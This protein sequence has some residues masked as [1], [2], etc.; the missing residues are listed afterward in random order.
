MPG[1]RAGLLNRRITIQQGQPGSGSEGDATMTW[2]PLQDVWAG[3]SPLGTQEL[4][5]AA[6]RAEEITHNIT[7]RF[8]RE[9]QAPEN[10]RLLFGNRIF[11]VV[12]A[13]D[14]DEGQTMLV[15]RCQEYVVGSQT[16]AS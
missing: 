9:F 12:G 4:I 8:Q 1:V 13:T 5:L 3:I 7:I 6:Q 2:M 15:L 16:G 11:F 10:L 14:P